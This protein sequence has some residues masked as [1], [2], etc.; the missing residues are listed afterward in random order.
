MLV[1]TG[2]ARA[3]GLEAREL[4]ELGTR[5]NWEDSGA[6]RKLRRA[7]KTGRLENCHAFSTNIS[8][9]TRRRRRRVGHRAGLGRRRTRSKPHSTAL[10]ACS[11]GACASICPRICAVCSPRCEAWA[12]VRSRARDS[13]ST[14]PPKCAQRS[15]RG[16]AVPVGPYGSRSPARRSGWRVC[17]G[18]G[19]RCDLGRLSMDPARQRLP[20]DMLESGR[21][22]QQVCD[23]R[24]AEGLRLAITATGT[25]SC[26]LPKARCSRR[27]PV[28]QIRRVM[29]QVDV[30]HAY[31]G[32][33]NPAQLIER[34]SRP[35]R[36]PAPEGYEEGHAGQSGNSHGISRPRTC[37]WAPDRSTCRQCSG[38]RSRRACPSTISKMRVSTPGDTSRRVWRFSR[39][40]SRSGARVRFVCLGFL[41]I[42]WVV[43]SSTLTPHFADRLVYIGT[44]T[45]R[46]GCRAKASM[47]FAST[48]P[49]VR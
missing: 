24:R 33:T 8:R 11:C 29:F 31:H 46:Q 22:I 30:F 48:T 49:R 21:G 3:S 40:S 10:S 5:R 39:V 38:Q 17:R 9:D 14:R 1:G 43:E 32:G 44:Y 34:Y 19:R 25:S 2:C 26:P 12:S 41:A 36:Q 42:A 18:K 4:G 6:R 28:P 16:L 23:G 7:W 45:G 13:G 47:P 27:S 20:R 37:R 15:M 35:R